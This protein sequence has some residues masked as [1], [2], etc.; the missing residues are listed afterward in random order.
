MGWVPKAKG[1]LAA[2]GVRAQSAASFHVARGGGTESANMCR[3]RQRLRVI[4]HSF[5]GT[6]P[7]GGKG[8]A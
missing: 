6:R 1:D 2:Q 3:S 8:E 5:T 4:D 7:N